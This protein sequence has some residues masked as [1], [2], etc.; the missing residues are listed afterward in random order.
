M[1]T[2]HF[3]LK[4]T[5]LG[6]WSQNSKMCSVLHSPAELKWNQ[7]H[8]VGRVALLNERSAVPPASCDSDLIA[9][10]CHTTLSSLSRNTSEGGRLLWPYK[11]QRGCRCGLSQAGGRGGAASDR[12]SETRAAGVSSLQQDE[13]VFSSEKISECLSWEKSPGSSFIAS[14]TCEAKIRND[15]SGRRLGWVWEGSFTARSVIWRSLSR[16]NNSQS[17][18]FKLLSSV[19]SKVQTSSQQDVLRWLFTSL[20]LV[21]KVTSGQSGWSLNILGLIW[22]I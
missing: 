17:S 16:S 3:D 4:V 12:R 5:E 6:N 20:S 13:K 11:E 22:P 19:D 21:E 8:P 1:A 15:R 18:D 7:Q 9:E 2:E 10:S 14:L